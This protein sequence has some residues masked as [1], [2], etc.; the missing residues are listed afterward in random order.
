MKIGQKP[1]IPPAI[2][3]QATAAGAG[4]TSSS[5]SATASAAAATA[6]A[7]QPKAPA[8]GVPVTVSS[9]ARSLEESNLTGTFDAKKVES[10]RT[11]INNGSYK[12]DAE[13]IADK[14]L[15]NARQVLRKSAN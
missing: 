14:L 7:Q 9:L 13:A 4:A 10:V 8:P 12:V 1:D 6:A 2:A 5:S 11:A 15:S 3:P